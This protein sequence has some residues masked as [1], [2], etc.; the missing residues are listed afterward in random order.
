[1]NPQPRCR[2]ARVVT[3]ACL[4]TAPVLSSAT[5]GA[6]EWPPPLA[7]RISIA[8][9]GSYGNGPSDS[10]A[11]NADGACVAFQ[12]AA[13][14]LVD[15]DTNAR[16]DVFVRDMTRN[17]TVRV[18]VA[19][20]GAQA[21]GHS[22]EPAVSGDCRYVAFTSLASNLVADDTNGTADVF[23]H[24][25]T[26]HV[27]TRVS[28][29]P[30]ATQGTRAASS[31]GV[32]GDGRLVVFDTAGNPQL[33]GTRV[34]VH[35]R[36]TGQTTEIAQPAGRS[37]REPAIS[38]DGR[39]VAFMSYASSGLPGDYYDDAL[40]LHDLVGAVTQRIAVAP[41]ADDPLR[42]RPAID[43]TGSTVAFTATSPVA[44]SPLRTWSV[45]LFDRASGLTQSLAY[46][47]LPRGGCTAVPCGATSR[48]S[49]DGLG[50]QVGLS[51]YAN[52]TSHIFDLVV[53][54][55][56]APIGLRLGE[57]T[58]NATLLTAN[59]RETALSGDGHLAAF[60]ANDTF[61]AGN[62]TGIA[63]VF[64]MVLG[65]TNGIPD[66]WADA[67]WLGRGDGSLD[68]DGDGVSNVDEYR[69]G[70]HP[71]GTFRQYLAEGATSDFLATTLAMAG[72]APILLTFQRSDGNAVRE[73]LASSPAPI[74]VNVGDIS[75]LEHA[76]FS[77]LAESPHP[78]VVDRTM[79][80]DRTR[81][82]GH[83]ESAVS[84]PRVAWYFAEGATHSGFDLF[85]LLQNPGTEPALVDVCYLLPAPSAPLVKRY[86]VGPASRH[87]IWVN[88]EHALLAAT[89]VSAIV[90]S[91]NGVPILAERA[92]YA[93]R[94]GRVFNAGHAAFG[95]ADLS[96]EWYFAEGSTGTMF[97]E[98]ITIA[99]PG[100]SPAD[101]DVTYLLPGGDTVS[102]VH[103]VA[104]A[105]RY[106]IWVDY[107]DPRLADTAVS[108]IVRT[109]NGLPI[110]AE[111]VLWW[112]GPTAAEWDEAHVV[113]GA[114]R[115]WRRWDI[116][117]GF[118]D[119][120][121]HMFVLMGN[122]ATVPTTARVTIAWDGEKASREYALA[123]TS[124]VNAWINADFAP[125]AGT[126]FTVTVECDADIVVERASYWDAEGRAWAGGTAALAAPQ[127]VTYSSEAAFVAATSATHRT[128]FDAV[129]PG[130]LALPF[131]L[132]GLTLDMVQAPV[133]AT[134]EPPGTSGFATNFVSAWL[135]PT[136]EHL[137]IR[138]PPGIRAAGVWVKALSALS[139][140]TMTMIDVAGRGATL[141]APIAD[142]G[143]HFL[144]VESPID[145]SEI[146]IS[147]LP[148]TTYGHGADGHP[149]MG[150]ILTRR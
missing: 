122:P 29:M 123:P 89:D 50:R 124:R 45:R 31:P 84:R 56:W 108:A 81:Y 19:S 15:D 27:T 145:I 70:T 103:Q 28:T 61:N 64:A 44:D 141:T 72:S 139:G 26:T 32:S 142:S 3:V 105:S 57:T 4:V 118:V 30:G 149:A 82:G 134:V 67:V 99:N 7:L 21:N 52:D 87:T 148:H 40:W 130:P 136:A 8:P 60:A 83:A 98:F 54:D 78:L 18:S 66:Y 2:V 46:R 17:T 91:A 104:P 121:T 68:T 42:G 135:S 65:A 117:D 106:T 114:A 41:G 51:Q 39:Y 14:N 92:L 125:P 100:E 37:L 49:L 69:A 150:D 13:T 116:A 20:D 147:T 38:A 109:R 48:P 101:I 23:V 110:A 77:T 88:L 43:A 132:D 120:T 138:F 131:S 140:T 12:S 94:P 93:S 55:R 74:V 35:D 129:A 5:L 59:T 79:T 25:R 1:M 76:E 127:A 111:R 86:V 36:T 58:D 115:A 71:A 53:V 128:T 95:L 16:I 24:D 96:S 97:D 22:H 75:G 33:G 143:P 80:W 90:Q 126:H 11:V 133:A 10:P 144:G 63:Q 85:Y 119:A 113:V 73:F 47:Q 146:R 9:D 62:T 112:P 34:Y 102:T 6:D 137:A 107:D